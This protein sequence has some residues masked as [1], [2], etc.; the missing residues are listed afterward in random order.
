MRDPGTAA[1]YTFHVFI[2]SGKGDEG[3][4]IFC[5]CERIIVEGAAFETTM[6]QQHNSFVHEIEQGH[7]FG[8]LLKLLRVSKQVKQTTI[9]A[10]LPGWSRTTYTRL[11]NGELPPHFDQLYALYRAFHLAGI[12]FSLEARQQFLDFARKQIEKKKTHLDKHTDTEWAELRYQL[13]RLD[14]SAPTAPERPSQVPTVAH[15]PLLAETS[16]LLGREDWHEH[17]L[18][19]V[20]SKEPKKLLIIRGPAGIGKSSE[21]N[22]LATYLFRQ[23]LTSYRVILCDFRS[24]ERM[25][26]PEEAFEVFLGTLLTELG[27]VQPQ[28]ALPSWEERTMLV[29]E[30]LEKV[31]RPT[32]ILIDH[33]ECILYEPGILAPCWER[34]LTKFLRSRH[35]ATLVFAT[36]QWP[37]WYGGEHQFVAEMTLPPLPSEKGVLLLQQLGLDGV[38]VSL[39]QEIYQKTGGIPLCLEWVAA[40]VKQ[41]LFADDWEEFTTFEQSNESHSSTNMTKAL[42]R[43]LQEPHLFGGTVADELAPFLERIL[44][45]QRLSTDA[46]ALLQ[47]LSV[48]S[49]PLAK[50]TLQVLCPQGSRPLKELRR[51]SVLVTYPDRAQLLPMVAAAMYRQLSSEEIYEREAHL[52]PAYTAWLQQDTFHEREQGPLITEL[53]T[54]LLKHHHLLDAAQL[55]IRYGWLS[56]NMGYAPRLAQLAEDV[57]QSF[58]RHSTEENEC[59]GLLLY[60]RLSPFLGKIIDDEGRFVDYQRIYDAAL[61]G[62][63][64]L[65]PSI[66][67]TIMYYLMTSIM[68]K[69]HFEEAQVLLEACCKRLAPFQ[70]YNIDLQA[71]LLEKRSWLLGAWCEYAL[72][73]ETIDKARELR[74]QALT[75]YRQSIHLLSNANESSTL[76][77]NML[78]KQLARAFNNLAYHLNRI[79]HYEEALQAIE[80]SIL[81]KEQGYVEVDTLADAYGEKSQILIGLGRFQ[82]A[83]LFDEKAIAE[84]QQGIDSQ[85]TYSQKEIWTHIVNR[86]CL[87]LRLG[88]VTEAEQLLQEARPHIRP[89]RRMYRMF[90]KDALNELEQ[91]RRQ[92]ISPKHQL[93]WRWVERYRQLDS[94]DSYWWLAPAGPFT[95]EEQQQWNQHVTK[96]LDEITKEQL[97]NLIAQSRDRELAAALD[98]QR[99]PHLL[100]PALD[101]EEVRRR[102]TGFAQLDAQISQEEPNVIVRRFYH[103]AIEDAMNFLRLI[104][105]TY[106]GDTEKFWEYNLRLNPLPTSDEMNDALSHVRR[107][108]RQGLQLARTEEVSNHILQF[109]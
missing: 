66:E 84:I 92:A 104:E 106:E 83:L 21:L 90:A 47:T 8:T 44:S 42:Q 61:T 3:A 96:P 55:L 71:S 23:R 22:W 18:S 29:L 63:L 78:K 108:L 73:Q 43:L 77:S 87:Y 14:G 24:I 31:T 62:K 102:L 53:A 45:T 35:V 41:P 20:H 85:Y 57:L 74:Q 12:S 109:L 16:H 70:S 15:R 6:R 46:N 103:G 67:I 9:V 4:E 27:Y 99:E 13:A 69:E 59:G 72:E 54:L 56:F 49:I 33:G 100:Y 19:F 39:L 91:W 37:G 82:E 89:K 36:K 101:I 5:S 68:D 38:P 25:S 86:G 81:L 34:F 60:Y 94:F 64:V 28:T 17:L 50:A 58:D 93:D 32:V 88:R 79:G 107:M 80:Q 95:K 1:W 98:Q 48:A 2:L 10:L 40:L 105:A 65:Q 30:Q 75:I 76:K 51:A 97:G 11:E 52:L 26:G 7:D